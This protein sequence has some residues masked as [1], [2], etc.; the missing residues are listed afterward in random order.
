MLTISPEDPLNEDASQLIDELSATLAA[1]TGDSGKSSFEPNDVNVPNALFVV[2]R[3]GKG[4]AVGCGAFRPLHDDV[5][6][7]KRMFSRH[8]SSGVGSAILAYLEVEAAK[9]GYRALW[10]ETRLVNERA[11][12]FY[13]A[14]GYK[15]IPNFGSYVGNVAAA[16]FEKQLTID[17]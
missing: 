17:Q 3:D 5:A 10:L 8:A 11:V 16:C 4:Q 2:A 13:E 12:S 6:E 7:V 14:R 9:L 1:I 15:R